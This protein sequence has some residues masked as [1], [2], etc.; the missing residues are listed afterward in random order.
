MPETGAD[1]PPILTQRTLIGEAATA[2][3]AAG[4]APRLG[5]GDVLAMSGPLGAGKSVFARALI[6]A[7]LAAV[8]RD[9]DVP[10]PTFTLVQTYEAGGLT[11]WHAD[12]YRLTTAE[13]MWE[14]GLDEAFGDALCLIEWPGLVAATLPAGMLHL[15]LDHGAEAGTRHL[16]VAS[17]DP[18]WAARLD[19]SD[20]AV[21]A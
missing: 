11:I 8:G 3:L 9:E 10:S 19:L 6:R 18:S 20:A 1:M 15:S 5:A 7:R 4:W 2:R 14:L 16:R 13:E 12:L 17:R 21:D